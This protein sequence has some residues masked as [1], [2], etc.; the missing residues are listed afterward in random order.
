MIRKGVGILRFQT[1]V[2]FEM[3]RTPFY[4]HGHCSKTIFNGATVDFQ[5]VFTHFIHV[6]VKSCHG[7]GFETG[8]N[9]FLL[10]E[11]R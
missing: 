1:T 11:T 9:L 7:A 4:F 8:L 2:G 5:V 3:R 6:F 10:F